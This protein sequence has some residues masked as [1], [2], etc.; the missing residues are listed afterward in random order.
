MVVILLILDVYNV[1]G[2]SF[3]VNVIVVYGEIEV[4]VVDIGF[5]KVDVLCIGVKVLDLGKILKMIFIF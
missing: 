1:D 3:Y 4:M 5:I 2:N